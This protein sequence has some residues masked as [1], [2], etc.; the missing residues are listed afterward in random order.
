MNTA[1]KYD[2]GAPARPLVSSVLIIQPKLFN[3]STI[4]V[5]C[6]VPLTAP[7]KKYWKKTLNASIM[8]GN[9]WQKEQLV[10]SIRNFYSKSSW[11]SLKQH[12]VKRNTARVERRTPTGSHGFVD[13][14]RNPS[15]SSCVVSPV[16]FAVTLLRDWATLKPTGSEY[17]AASPQPLKQNEGRRHPWDDFSIL[18]ASSFIYLFIF[19]SRTL[20]KVME[21]L[22]LIKKQNVPASQPL[23]NVSGIPR[24]H[25]VLKPRLGSKPSVKL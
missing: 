23:V 8:Q 24:M 21:P 9:R 17:P 5:E 4:I 25:R 2:G 20:V 6:M 19:Y 3:F 1:V 22:T 15:E 13:C 10:I 12:G 7:K 11:G 14:S 16:A 18:Y